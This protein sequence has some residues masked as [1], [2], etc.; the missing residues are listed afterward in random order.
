MSPQAT[1]PGRC[2]ICLGEGIQRHH[3][4]GQ[5]HI[6]W[7]KMP[8]CERHHAQITALVATAKIDLTYTDDPVERCI[9]AQEASLIFQWMLLQAQRKLNYRKDQ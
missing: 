4:G 5:N 7:F 1:S 6:A 9:R 2:V 8:L 3:V